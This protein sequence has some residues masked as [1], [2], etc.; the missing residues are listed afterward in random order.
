MVVVEISNKH[1][2]VLLVIIISRRLW[3][4]VRKVAF[5]ISSVYCRRQTV[6]SR[7][8]LKWKCSNSRR[9]CRRGRLKAPLATQPSTES[10]SSLETP[11]SSKLSYTC[12][13][14]ALKLPK[15]SRRRIYSTKWMET[16]D[17]KL[18][19]QTMNCIW[20]LT[21]WRMTMG[22][23][24]KSATWMRSRLIMLSCRIW[25]LIVY[26]VAPRPITRRAQSLTRRRSTEAN[27]RP[28]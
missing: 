2:P 27:F 12:L 3:H 20:G 19:E 21:Q 23:P 16:P 25:G 10:R 13:R 17:S 11:A 5:A 22:R 1:R 6:G 28:S 18:L 7:A 8:R 9:R 26:Q 15:R 4:P 24:C 14:L